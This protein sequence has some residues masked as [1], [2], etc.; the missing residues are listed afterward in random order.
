MVWRSSCADIVDAR[1][2]HARTIRALLVALLI[3]PLLAPLPLAAQEEAARGWTPPPLFETD[4]LLRLTIRTDLRTL[5]NDRDSTRR[6]RHDA[7][8]EIAGA[9][10]ETTTVDARLRT[11]GHFRRQAR[12]CDFPPIQVNFSGGTRDTPF[13]RQGNLKLVT[14]CQTRRPEYEQYILQEYLLYR[15]YNAL[16]PYSFRVRLAQITYEDTEG[17]HPGLTTYAFFIEPERDMARRNGGLILD[18][19]GARL[20][21]V[22]TLQAHLLSAWQYMAGNTDWSIAGQHNIVLVRSDTTKPGIM[23]VHPVPYD[24]DWTGVVNARYARPDYRLPIRTVRERLYRGYCVRAADLQ[25]A[26]E[27]MQQRRPAMEAALDGVPGLEPATLASLKSYFD[28]FWR[29]V[30]NPRTLQREMDRACLPP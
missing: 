23:T 14:R 13:A 6:V 30:E 28:D 9:N 20:G 27:H 4:S 16:T 17:R 19:T 26:I 7:K 8:I 10:G 12:I 11:R 29:I 18:A 15:T 1:G 21:D 25:P 5:I 22:D 3:V 2:R 24:F